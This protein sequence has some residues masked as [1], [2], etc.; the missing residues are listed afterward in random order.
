M[1]EVEQIPL[2]DRAT[3]LGKSFFLPV[4]TPL[5][6]EIQDVSVK[7]SSISVGYVPDKC[8]IIT[9]PNTGSFGSISNKLF[10]G[11]KITV[12]YMSKGSVFGF[13]TELVGVA[14][15]PMR[16]LFLG[17]PTLVARRALRSNKRVECYLPADLIIERPEST[18]APRQV[19]QGIAEDLSESGCSYCRLSDAADAPFPEIEVGEAV[20]LCLRLP[21][22]ENDVRLSGEVRRIQR[23]S[24]KIGVGVRFR[25]LTEEK[26]RII[27]D[28][29]SLLERFFEE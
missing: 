5:Q 7:M 8:L 14:N 17:F 11:N 6:I 29:I 9:Y 19:F 24:R 4:G 15:D 23:D 10:K 2:D 12:R 28:Y 13:H 20:E 27:V 25:D 1:A 3:G 16:L 22:P 26:K 21:G 18:N